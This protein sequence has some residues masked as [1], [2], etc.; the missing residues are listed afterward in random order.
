MDSLT[1]NIQQAECFAEMLHTQDEKALTH[2]RCRGR[3]TH[4]VDSFQFLQPLMGHLE[5]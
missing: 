4:C 5:H 2:K 1:Q 3:R